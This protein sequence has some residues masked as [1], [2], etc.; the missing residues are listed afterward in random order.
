MAALALAAKLSSM[1]IVLLVTGHTIH[2]RFQHFNT[3]MMTIRTH[4]LAV[5]S[6]QRK[7]S[8]FGVI[9]LPQLPAIG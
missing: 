8:L 4:Q 3:N 7:L 2:R 9:E 1:H 6:G 5:R